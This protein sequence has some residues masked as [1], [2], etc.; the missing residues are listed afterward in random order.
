MARVVTWIAIA[1]VFLASCA[2]SYENQ[3]LSTKQLIEISSI[4]RSMKCAFSTAILEE[5]REGERIRLT[6]REVH[7]KYT[8]NLVDTSSVG[9]SGEA[10]PAGPFVLPLSLGLG[11]I[12]PRIGSRTTKSRTVMTEIAF[13]YDLF[14]DN[15]D[16]CFN[17]DGSEADIDMEFSSWLKGVLKE[18]DPYVQYDPP[19]FVDSITY[20]T[21][22]GVTRD[23]SAGLGINIVL[24]SVDLENSSKREDV[25]AV[26]FTIRAANPAR[27]VT[28][29]AEPK[30]DRRQVKTERRTAPARRGGTNLP[31][32]S[33]EQPPLTP[34]SDVP[35]SGSVCVEG[36]PD[37]PGS[38]GRGVGPLVEQLKA[39]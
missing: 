7:G 31:D 25:Q 24:L 33:S 35:S 4:T 20:K 36:A 26:E 6:G 2:R 21:Q 1:S 32:P 39:C 23:R 37:L 12:L 17:P 19:A 9:L 14:A 10:L 15:N 29:P 8:F 5:W 28:G 16:A 11:S 13:R 38:E 27:Q 3:L 30:A 22:F 18:L 34:S